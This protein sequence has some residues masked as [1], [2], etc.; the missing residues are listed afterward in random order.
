MKRILVLGAGKS[1]TA[2]IDYLIGNAKEYGWLVV[3]AD[4]DIELVEKKIEGRDNTEALAI[5]IMEAKDRETQI[6]RADFVI[7]MLPAFLHIHVA[8][9]CVANK[10]NLVT[11]SYVSDE[12]L[13][14]HDEAQAAGILLMNE[15]GADPGIDHMSAMEI[16]ERIR[17]QGGTVT[18]FQ[19]YCGG[20]VAPESDTNPWHYK[21]AW[22][23]WNIV[24]AGSSGADFL[25]NGTEY[26]RTYENLYKESNIV[27]VPGYGDL[28]AYANRNSLKYIDDY[29][30]VHAHTVLRATLRHPDFMDGW[31][32][33]IALG[34][35]DDKNEFDITG[36]TFN[37]W[38]IKVTKKIKG[39]TLSEKIETIGS[40]KEV[41]VLLENLGVASE[42]KISLEGIQSPGKVV[43]SILVEKWKLEPEDK[44][45]LIFHHDIEYEIDEDSYQLESSMIVKGTNQTDTAMAKCVGLPMAIFT[46]IF[47]TTG[48]DGLS[49]VQ[50]PTVK[51]VYE[52]VLKELKT[53]GIEFEEK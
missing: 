2:L 18:S 8:K 31:A 37:Q 24:R 25:M 16:I 52:P 12:I 29:E 35:T 28:A 3:I 5:D 51:Q 44:D 48:F 11:A 50:I 1:A 21:V 36:L 41:L 26:H 30:L 9:D 32:A 7:S 38:F 47:L 42:E 39:D 22:N 53:F 6:K 19:S 15:M 49:G 23:P 10:T 13:Q 45:L 34:L 14:L 4:R 27:E 46:K 40:T 33:M 20:L 17:K 43:Q